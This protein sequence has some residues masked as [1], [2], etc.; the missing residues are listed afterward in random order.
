MFGEIKKVGDFKLS[1]DGVSFDEFK[2]AVKD[3]KDLIDIYKA[4]DKN[5]DNKLSR[6][7]LASL[8]GAYSQIDNGDN[9]LKHKERKALEAKIEA[10]IKN[11][12]NTENDNVKIK[13]KKLDGFYTTLCNMIAPKND[14]DG[15]TY[16]FDKLGNIVGGTTK[17]GKV[18]T[19]TNTDNGY[20]ITYKDMQIEEY[21]NKSGVIIGGKDKVG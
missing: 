11:D 16:S 13:T 19:R 1:G 18:Y 12:E 6:D 15:E 4:F 2:K 21:Y 14:I 20:N 8:L 17:D 10:D 5:G 9:K 7:E 3:N